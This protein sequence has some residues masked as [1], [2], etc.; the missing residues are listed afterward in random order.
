MPK[1]FYLPV[2]AVMIA[3]AAGG[4]GGSEQGFQ[5]DPGGMGAGGPERAGSAVDSAADILQ[6]AG[7]GPTTDTGTIVETGRDLAPGDTIR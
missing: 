1:T 7:Y 6:G 4:C 5:G 3:L 2:A